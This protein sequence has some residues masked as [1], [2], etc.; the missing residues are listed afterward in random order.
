[1]KRRCITGMNIRLTL[2]ALPIYF[3]FN[4]QFN[5]NSLLWKFLIFT[6]PKPIYSFLLYVPVEISIKRS[7]EKLEPFPDS[8]ETL[9]YRFNA[10]LDKNFLQSNSF[11]KINCEIPLEEAH[12]EIMLKIKGFL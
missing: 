6:I 3:N 12:E 5:P 9:H 8:E 10:Y 4:N 2:L 7:K 1:M 11:H